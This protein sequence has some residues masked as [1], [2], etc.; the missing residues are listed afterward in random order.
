MD[1]L[2][3]TGG[4]GLYGGSEF[5]LQGEA[6]FRINLGCPRS[7]LEQGLLGIQRAVASL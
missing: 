2:V 3:N 1:R 4:V 5:G 7:R 6:F